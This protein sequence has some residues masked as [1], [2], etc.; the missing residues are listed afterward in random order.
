MIFSIHGAIRHIQ[1]FPEK[2]CAIV[3]YVTTVG[4]DNALAENKSNNITNANQ[5]EKDEI[6]DF[7][8]LNY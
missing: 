4:A 7:Y 5:V 2:H 1:I 8:G 6:D 3:E